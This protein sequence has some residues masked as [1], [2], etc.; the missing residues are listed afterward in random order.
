MLQQFVFL[1]RLCTWCSGQARPNRAM[2]LLPH[3]LACL[4]LGWLLLASAAVHAAGAPALVTVVEGDARLIRGTTAYELAEGMRLVDQDIVHTGPKA[5]LT[6]LEWPDGTF[7]NL[8]PDTRVLLIPHD[9]TQADQRATSFYLLSGWVKLTA[10][11][12]PAAAGSFLAPMLD[13]DELRGVLV[14]HLDQAG[15][16]VFAE[17]GS[18]RLG[19]RADGRSEAAGSLR[20][21][22]YRYVP[23]PGQAPASVPPLG[24]LVQ[25]MPRAFMDTLPA[26]GARFAAVQTEPADGTVV[27]YE[28]IVMWLRAEPVLRRAMLP[29]WQPL[30][31][32]RAFRSAVTT[33]LKFHPEWE[34]PLKNPSAARS[35][36]KAAGG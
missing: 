18:A 17:R 30:L 20:Q 29:R 27:A 5:R 25:A 35:A 11:G 14:V 16:R 26:L 4:I 15:A 2:K 19:T 8:G 32:D 1:A 34:R 33:H 7:L 13:I 28:D 24:A 3:T 12:P 10:P 23:A 9:A 21:G 31:R 22:E 36:G 6:R